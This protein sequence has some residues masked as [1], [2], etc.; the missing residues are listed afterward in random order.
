LPDLPNTKKVRIVGKKSVFRIRFRIKSA[1]DGF[2]DPDPGDAKS[3]N[4][5]KKK[6]KQAKRQKI[7]KK[8]TY[9]SL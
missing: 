4:I 5:E 3:A 7:H 1:L 6:K 2:L 8:L 9:S